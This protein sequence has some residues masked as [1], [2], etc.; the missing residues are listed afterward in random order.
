MVDNPLFSLPKQHMFDRVYEHM[1]HLIST[2]AVKPGERIKDSEWATRLGVSRTPVR[3]AIRKLHQEG[4]MVEL[5]TG[6]YQL[7][8][9]T[10]QELTALYRCRAALESAATRE[11]A[12]AG[13][14][15]ALKALEQV[16]QDTDEAIA[17]AD[18]PRAFDLNTQFHQVIIEGC[19][20][21][22]IKDML[23]S[24]QRMI[25]FYRGNALSKAQSSADDTDIYLERL[26]IKQAHHRAIVNAIAAG[27]DELAA[28]LMN[29]HVATTVEDLAGSIEQPHVES[30]R[31]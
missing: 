27:K 29:E 19:G 12:Q 7:R 23:A 13:D 30:R 25:R 10:H 3:E 24:L 17:G 20:N 28:K 1:L 4:L 9:F 6:G 14:P 16:L 15:A 18:L 31:A 8:K 11:F 26:K 2:G 22:F 21:G 5:P